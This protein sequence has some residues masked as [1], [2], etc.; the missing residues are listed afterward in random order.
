[1]CAASSRKRSDTTPADRYAC[2]NCSTSS[3]LLSS[4]SPSF[5]RSSSNFRTCGGG[6]CQL[7][8]GRL[9][10]QRHG[11]AV[12][13]GLEKPVRVLRE[14]RIEDAT[15]HRRVEI[16]RSGLMWLVGWLG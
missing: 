16:T 12:S 2:V 15:D 9:R 4:R 14:L 11:A 1:M 10:D 5:G 3:E 7:A 13:D 6:R 8:R